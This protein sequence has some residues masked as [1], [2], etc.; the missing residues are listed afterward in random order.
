MP[1][2]PLSSPAHVLDQLAAATTAG[3]A[4]PAPPG[5]LAVSARV[6]DPRKRRGVRHRLAAVLT[7]AT[8][9]V[10]AGARSFTAIGE[11]AAD[12]GETV[13][14][15][16]GIA[17]VPDESTFRRATCRPWFL[18]GGPAITRM[19]WRQPARGSGSNTGPAAATL[20]PSRVGVRSGRRGAAQAVSA[21]GL[22]NVDAGWSSTARAVGLV[23]SESE[24]V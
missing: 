17:R 23:R 5:L 1:A 7:L 10:L 24:S 9:A 19:A 18:V 11:W 12:A 4:P 20:A 13:A 21:P 15:P 22:G 6:P 16:L 14:G 2:A 3:G 8:C